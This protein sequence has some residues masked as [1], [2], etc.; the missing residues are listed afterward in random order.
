MKFLMIGNIQSKFVFEYLTE[1]ISGEDSLK[2]TIATYQNSL[3]EIDE[4]KK[5]YCEKNGINIILINKIYGGNSII[6]KF[7][8]LLRRFFVFRFCR[9]FDIIQMLFVYGFESSFIG[10]WAKKKTRILLS[11][12]GSD[13]L[14]K[15]S[16]KKRKFLK[17]SLKRADVITLGSTNMVNS[18]VSIFGDSYLPKVKRIDF[19]SKNAEIILDYENKIDSVE[20]KKVIGLDPSKRTILCGYNGK[21]SQKHLEIIDSLRFL[22]EEIKNGIQLVFHLGYGYDDEYAKAIEGAASLSGISYVLIKDF[23]YNLRLVEFRKSIDIMLNLQPTDALSNSMMESLYC[24]TLVIKGEWLHYPDLDDLNIYSLSINDF[25]D[26]NA[27]ITDVVVNFESYKKRCVNNK[28]C[29]QLMSWKPYK[30]QW[31]NAVLGRENE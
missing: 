12:F 10:F 16:K 3:D 13:L 28:K 2:V 19:G 8:G 25:S 14:S 5:E 17:V 11:F 18:F 23:Y 7:F 4:E 30:N 15:A 27:L 22:R 9:K 20:C 26:L 24:G 6:K 21:Q 1:I 29:Y 31:L